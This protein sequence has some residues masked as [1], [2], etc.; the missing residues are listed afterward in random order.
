MVCERC[1]TMVETALKQLGHQEIKVGLGS[2]SFSADEEKNNL[3][4]EKNLNA[5]GFSLAEDEKLKVIDQVKSLVE[6]VYSGE[7]DFPEN[8]R[9]ATM[10]S[11][12]LGKAYKQI[13]ELFISSEKLTIEQYI[14]NYRIN[15]VKE[16]L[17]YTPLTLTDIAFTMNYSSVAHLSAQFKQITGLT[18]TYFRGIKEK[19]TEQMQ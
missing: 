3:V 5:L 19:K 6:N 16:L 14:I 1:I 15:K 8:F 12:K 4:L 9:F 13:S 10:V 2:V 7:F 17:V 11:E 18:P